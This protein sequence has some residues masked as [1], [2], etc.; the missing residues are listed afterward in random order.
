MFLAEY[1]Q[2]L[3]DEHELLTNMTITDDNKHMLDKVPV[4]SDKII[5]LERTLSE[6]E[7]Q[8]NVH[9]DEIDYGVF[10]K[11]KRGQQ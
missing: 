10:K 2:V 7:G 1:L 4:L 8:E 11:R 6:L 3:K 5:L 9:P